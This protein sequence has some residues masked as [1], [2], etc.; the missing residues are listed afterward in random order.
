VKYYAAQLAIEIGS[1]NRES[2]EFLGKL[3]GSLENV[4][5]ILIRME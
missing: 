1:K 5:G 2:Q 4:R 3:V